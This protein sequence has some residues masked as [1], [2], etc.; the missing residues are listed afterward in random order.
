MRRP[1][2]RRLCVHQLLD[3]LA[4]SGSHNGRSGQPSKVRNEDPEPRRAEGER[5]GQV[6]PTDSDRPYWNS[7][8]MSQ[9][10]S[11]K[12]T[13]MIATATGDQ[14]RV[15]LDRPRKQQRERHREMKQHQDHADEPPARLKPV[16]VPGDLLGRLP[17]QMIKY[18]ENEKYAHSMTKAS[19]R[20][21][22]S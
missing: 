10:R 9:N 8:A 17:A 5:D 12:R 13:R 3:R 22:K 19:S 16:L 11:T 7:G 1:L 6:Q 20:L 18:C 4:N 21:P 14:P 15:P 2:R